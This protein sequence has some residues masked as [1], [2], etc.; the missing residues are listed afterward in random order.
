MEGSSFPLTF[1][2]HAV[3]QISTLGDEGGAYCTA[4]EFTDDYF[5]LHQ[6]SE[7]DA[8]KQE[9][10]RGGPKIGWGAYCIKGILLASPFK[11]DRGAAAKN[12]D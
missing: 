2:D 11:F 4:F 5:K 7:P 3:D 9:Q 10:D 1:G 8:G 12:D 6:N